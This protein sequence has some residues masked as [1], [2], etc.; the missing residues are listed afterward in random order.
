MKGVSLGHAFSIFAKY[1]QIVAF[2]L[3]FLPRYSTM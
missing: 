1:E 2:F 3:R